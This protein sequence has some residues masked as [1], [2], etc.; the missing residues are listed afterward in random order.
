MRGKHWTKEDKEY[1]EENWGLVYVEYIAN[2]LNRDV[3]AVLAMAE[4][5]N[6]GGCY[7][8]GGFL[9][10]NTVAK[11]F[12]ISNKTVSNYWIKKCGLV[13]RKRRLIKQYMWFIDIEDLTEWLK[14]NQDKWDSRRVELFALGQEPEWLKEKRK[15]D[16]K[17]PINKRKPWTSIEK[18]RVTN[19][20]N[21]G[22]SK[23][24]I[25]SILG[26]TEHAIQRQISK[27]KAEGSL[28]KD[29]VV[30]Y[31][32]KEEKELLFELEKQGLTDKEIAEELGRED[33]HISDYR[34]KLRNKGLYEGNKTGFR[35]SR[36]KG[37]CEVGT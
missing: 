28:K 20:F 22:K 5:M 1:L 36:A 24:E 8:A 12:G 16:M 23:K 14:N 33:F 17:E 6:L 25:A 30:L 21:Q 3:T 29:R 34:R 4:S 26:R 7:V 13:A 27:L 15:A 37:G 2:K 19:Y 31:W 35:F 11:I 9:N 18:Q 10:A 32:Q